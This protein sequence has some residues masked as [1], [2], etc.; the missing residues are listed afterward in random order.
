VLRG[1]IF[2]FDGVIVD[3]HP[4]HLRAWKK[5][6]LSMGRVLSDEELQFVLDG[7]KSSDI[8]KHYLGDI[9]AERIAE[10]GRRKEQLF[11]EE[12]PTVRTVAGL[13]NLLE[14]LSDAK[15]AVGIASSGSR[16]RVSS[17]LDRLLLKRYF[18][19]VVTGDQ[20]EHGKPDPALFLRAALELQLD[21]AELMAF[22]D[23]VSGVKA[24]R[25]AGIICVGVAQRNRARALQEA[26]A[27]QTVTDFQAVSHS[28]LQRWFTTSVVPGFVSRPA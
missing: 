20:V 8:L 4:A 5:F 10:Y 24:A 21:P 19:I 13:F 1:I 14:D 16:N 12:A 15:V 2:D 25:G 28:T 17:L 6:F 3:S 26:G 23:A 18:Q 7:H 9:D 22:E 11:L 27:V